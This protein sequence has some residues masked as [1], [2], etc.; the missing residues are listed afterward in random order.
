MNDSILIKN[1]LLV[2]S[3]FKIEE[4]SNYAKKDNE[5]EL[6]LNLNEINDKDFEVE[7]TLEFERIYNND[8]N[9]ISSLIIMKGI[10]QVVDEKPS[11]YKEYCYINAPATIYPYLREHLSDMSVKA[12]LEPIIISPFNFVAFGKGFIKELKDS[13]LIE[14]PEIS[15]P[16]SEIHNIPSV[17]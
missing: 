8:K 14:K 10:F 9:K 16:K 4:I 5:L 11:Y 6:K 2:Y 15:E 3:N 1:I 12:G 17:N 7:L 13:V